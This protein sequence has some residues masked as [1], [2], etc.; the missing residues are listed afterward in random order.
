[1]LPGKGVKWDCI[2]LIVSAGGAKDYCTPRFW[3]NVYDRILL[4]WNLRTS[5]RTGE[6]A[7]G[8]RP[9][10]T[11]ALLRARTR[12]ARPRAVGAPAMPT[13]RPAGLISGA[14][15]HDIVPATNPSS[16]HLP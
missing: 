10:Q 9:R 11:L 4:L 16:V 12:P 8:F 7:L 5:S 14:G 2:N 3:Y 1:M 6:D 15:G 13:A